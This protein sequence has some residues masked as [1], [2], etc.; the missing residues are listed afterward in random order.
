MQYPLS[1]FQHI[2][3]YYMYDYTVYVPNS[4]TLYVVRLQLK[5]PHFV[6][7]YA[8]AGIWVT[9]VVPPIDWTAGFSGL[10]T[11]HGD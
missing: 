3:K 6:A 10:L 7:R 1:N 9:A 5:Q 2:V 4:H 11:R 8:F